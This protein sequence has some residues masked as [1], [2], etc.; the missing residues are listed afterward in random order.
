[1]LSQHEL[2]LLSFQLEPH[3]G[4]PR[5]GRYTSVNRDFATSLTTPRYLVETEQFR[6]P[7]EFIREAPRLIDHGI[8]A[9]T[10]IAE[11]D[12]TI[13]EL[14]AELTRLNSTP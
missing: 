1:M 13:A 11:R 10:I 12:A 14:R 9:L 8:E 2:K 4:A 7:L 3:D 5:A 6:C